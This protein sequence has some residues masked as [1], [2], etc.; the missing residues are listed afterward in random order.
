MAYN[1]FQKLRD[2]I[3][4][5]R[6]ALAYRAG[7]QISEADA[8]RLRKYAGFGGLKAV[9]FPAGDKSEWENRNAS[10]N[11]LK[12]Y[13]SIMELHELLKAQFSEADYKAA[14]QSMR[15]SVLTAYYTPEV[16]PQILYQVL[17]AQNLQPQRLYEPSSGA[18]IFITEAVK[19]LPDLQQ[20]N[21]VEKDILTGRIL[22]ALAG[23]LPVITQVQVK[24]FEETS[25]A[26]NGTYDLIAS[27]IPF[28]NFQVY[29]ENIRDKAL[30][31]KIHNYFFAKGL[32]KLADGGLMAFVTSDGFLNN[33]SN[34]KA[35]QYLFSKADFISVTVLPDNLMKET[36]NTEA[37]SHLLIVQKNDGK[38]ELSPEEKL[39]IQ[40]VQRENEYGQYEYNQ[41]ISRH[42]ELICGDEVKA[43][44]NQYGTAHEVVWQSGEISVIAEKLSA[45]LSEDI[46]GRIDRQ[47]FRK[48]LAGTLTEQETEKPKLTYLPM[49][50]SK[51]TNVTVQLGLFDTTP[52]ENIN[53]AMDYVHE[54]DATVIHKDT[55]RIIGIVK[56]KDNP[57][58]ES[59]VLI[60]AKHR[61]S[62]HYLYK[63]YANFSDLH[64]SANWMNGGLLAHELNG[65]GAALQKYDHDYFF[66]GDKSLEQVF[67]L[68]GPQE[69]YFTGLQPFH[70]EGS[71]V[72]LN[73]QVG[74]LGKPDE[75]KN[76]AVFQPLPDQKDAAFYRQYIQVRDHYYE[77]SEK[78]AAALIAYTGLR[79]Q[80][81]LAYAAFIQQYGELNRPANRRLILDD[82]QDGFKMLSSIERKDGNNYLPADILNGPVFQKKEIFKTDDPVSALARCLNE[83]GKVDTSFIASATD[84]TVEETIISL[85]GHICLNPKNRECET[86]DQYLSGNVVEKLAI[87]QKQAAQYPDDAHIQSSLEAITKVQPRPISFEELEFNLGERWFPLDYYERFAKHL[88]ETDTAIAY[89]QSGDTFKVTPSRNTMK[90]LREY[91]VSPKGGKTTYGYTLLEHALENTTPFFTY[92]IKSGDKT[93]RVPDNEAIQLA[94]QKIENIR[95]GFVNWL[96]ELPDTDKQYLEK[97]YNDTFNCYVLREYN[98]GH[99]TFPGL[100]KKALG[101]DDLYSSQKNAAW[102]IM[103]NRGALIDHEVGLGKTLTMIV[104]AHEMKRLGIVHKPMILAL[105]A[106]V[107]QIAETYRKAYPDARILAPT[108]NDFEPAKR[109]RLF[110]H[111]DT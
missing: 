13:P 62:K 90:I 66:E 98:G 107:N 18:G 100:D 43:G 50:E 101:I 91:A 39:L 68:G 111:P 55:A 24:G 26:E 61:D 63:F 51:A 42:P 14:I 106:N 110:H 54:L 47:A 88:F 29:D 82:T 57:Q 46:T 21:A 19:A 109:L 12:L 108:E 85:R 89:F 7:D 1:Q 32:D 27:N 36:G 65:L 99:L 73:N 77:L 8:E 97:L 104:A 40:T 58:H 60:T 4:A 76:R 75:T 56:T 20:I 15:D 31:G 59:L 67:N 53:R 103:Q 79:E 28:G 94:N 71:L 17:I 9:L 44:K 52:A 83:K 80:L 95:S 10:K 38:T 3:A 11:D 2:N 25:N 70:R 37:P 33:G 6:I 102:R 93:K 34:E 81:Q 16:V 96:N 69:T 72:A 92:E 41:Y 22:T 5:I 49:P 35:R 64:F 74:T 105:K 48:S 23:T 30:T 78:E 45:R 84:M 87:A 86:T